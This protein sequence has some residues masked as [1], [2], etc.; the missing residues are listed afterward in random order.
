MM[1]FY[2]D[3]TPG[4]KLNPSTVL[5]MAVAYIGGVVA[6]H[7]LGKLFGASTKA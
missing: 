6:L 5:V 3:E 2:T 4:I 7:I 1:K